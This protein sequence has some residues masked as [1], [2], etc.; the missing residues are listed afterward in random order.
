[1][2]LVHLTLANLKMIVRNRQALFWSM[3]FPVLMVVVFGLIAREPDTSI[4]IAVV[5]Y[6]N[7]SVSERLI[8]SLDQ[9]ANYEIDIRVDEQT[10]REEVGDGDLSYLLVLPAGLAATVADNPPARLTLVYDDTSPISGVV[11]VSIE[12]FLDQVN[13]DIANA[14]DRLALEPEGVLTQ[15]VTFIAFLLPGIAVWGIMSFSVIG[16]ATT[17][18]SYREKK[19]LRRIMATPLKVRTFFVAQVLAYLLMAL[20]QASVIL[21]LGGLVYDVPIVGNLLLIGLVIIIGNIVFLN[22]GFIVG[23]YSKSVQTAS[24]LGNLVVLPLLMFSGVFFSPDSL[25]KMLTAVVRFMPLAPMVET[26]RGVTLEAKGI[27]D[28]PTQIA[29]L[30][31]WIGVTSLVAVKVFRFE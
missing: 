25:P 30:A 28:F 10:A 7:D 16:I 13:L 27:G 2:L 18:A 11:I 1:M 4:H 24:G 23:A 31:V 9:V 8:R 26:V 3:A 20:V 17:M 15:D 22:L 5:D 19:I 21:G 29:I 6:A 12:R 14:I